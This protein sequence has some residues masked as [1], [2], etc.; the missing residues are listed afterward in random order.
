MPVVVQ[1]FILSNDDS[2]YIANHANQALLY[3]LNLAASVCLFVTRGPEDSKLL[4]G[5][6]TIIEGKERCDGRGRGKAKQVGVSVACDAGKA[7][8]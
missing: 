4:C 8:S 5:P 2:T 6:T 1:G 3:A 7:Q